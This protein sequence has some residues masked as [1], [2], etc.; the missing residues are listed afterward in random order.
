MET[1]RAAEH[2]AHD[3][4]RADG[5][6]VELTRQR[7]HDRMETVRPVR[8]ALFVDSA[9]A[10]VTSEYAACSKSARCMRLLARHWSDN[11]GAIGA[12]M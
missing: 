11:L 10:P 9:N 8:R 4:Q 12:G 1:R 6:G 2:R 5:D 3:V 7:N